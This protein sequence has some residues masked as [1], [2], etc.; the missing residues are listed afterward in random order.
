LAHY[1]FPSLPHLTIGLRNQQN[2][3]SI[4]FTTDR[5]DQSGDQGSLRD[6]SASL[7]VQ[8]TARFELLHK[9]K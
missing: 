5:T 4:G 9:K 3:P 7:T 8:H 2:A 1:P 6:V